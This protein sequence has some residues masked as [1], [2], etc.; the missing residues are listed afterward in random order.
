MFLQCFRKRILKYEIDHNIVSILYF[1]AT[2][3]WSK[4]FEN[5]INIENKYYTPSLAILIFYT[6]S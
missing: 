4:Y 2:D 5:T 6:L 3:T 1:S